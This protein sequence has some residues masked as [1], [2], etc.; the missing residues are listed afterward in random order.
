M[1]YDRAMGATLLYGG[2]TYSTL[3]GDTWAFSKAKGWMQLTPAVSP[4]PGDMSF[5]DRL[6]AYGLNPVVQNATYENISWPNEP[7]FGS[8]PI[9][10]AP[11]SGS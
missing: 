3:F 1:V 7:T 5:Y 9:T 10:K 11:P 4:S 8:A 6:A 2:N